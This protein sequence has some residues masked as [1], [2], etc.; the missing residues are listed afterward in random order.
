MNKLGAALAASFL[1]LNSTPSTLFAQWATA[2][3]DLQI[4]ILITLGNGESASGFFI[5]S[6][7]HLFLATAAH[8]L[9]DENSGNLKSDSAVL[10]WEST[11]NA[12]CTIQAN[13]QVLQAHQNIRKNSVHDVAVVRCGLLLTTGA[14]VYDGSEITFSTNIYPAVVRSVD[15]R[16]LKNVNIGDDVYVF[17][18]PSSVGLKQSPKFDYSRPLLRKGI[19]SGI[20]DEA[21]TITIDAAVY[22]GNSGGPVIEKEE[23]GLGQDTYMII[24]IVTEIIPFVEVSE[25]QT[26]HYPN[27]NLSNSGYG[28][29]QPVDFILQLLWDN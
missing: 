29:V 14:Q 3:H 18:Y 8:V 2:N 21:Q 16:K 19:V 6:S 28:V 23:I 9:Y 24:G 7:N 12:L 10:T 26:Y 20:Y 4:P 13:L 15:V 17:G 1:F 27:Y 5:S 11:N 22:F 25:N